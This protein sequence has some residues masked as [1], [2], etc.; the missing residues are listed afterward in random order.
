MHVTPFF[1]W[2]RFLAAII[3]LFLFFPLYRIPLALLFAGHMGIL[4]YGV[5]NIQFQFFGKVYNRVHSDSNKIA[6]TFDDGPD[7]NLT[8]DILMVLKNHSISATF[9]VIGSKAKKYESLVKKCYE[10]GHTVACHDLNHSLFSNFRITKYLISD[11][12]ES[13]NIIE[14]IIGKK[15]LLYRPP[16]GLMNP[17]TLKALTYL[18]MKCIGWSGS[19]RDA[20]N[21]RIKKIKQIHKLAKKGEV[22]MLHDVLPNS[23]YKKI[24]LEQLNELCVLI[25][26]QKLESVTVDNMFSLQAYEG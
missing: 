26:R 21:R 11:I 19:V 6:L 23:D 1:I 22:V 24:V 18:N 17:H 16:V 10:A 5:K 2:K 13:R 3:L 8:D 4:F 7:P 25:N 12:C 15:P 20:G 14:N 9:F